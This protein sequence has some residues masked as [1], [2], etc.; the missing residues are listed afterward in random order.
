[1][2]WAFFLLSEKI[3][4]LLSVSVCLIRGSQESL[5]GCVKK[6]K[7]HLVMFRNLGGVCRFQATEAPGPGFWNPGFPSRSI[8][9]FQVGEVPSPLGPPLPSLCSGA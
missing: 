6:T 1:M 4:W 5:R 2:R 9:H 7:A 3:G 8:S